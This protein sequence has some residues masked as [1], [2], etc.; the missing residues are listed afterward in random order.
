M[1]L[2]PAFYLLQPIVNWVVTIYS[3]CTALRRS[4]GGPRVGPNRTGEVEV[5]ADDNADIIAMYSEDY[6]KTMYRISRDFYPLILPPPPVKSSLSKTPR[7]IAAS[8]TWE[9][10]AT[11]DTQATT[12][13]DIS[14]ASSSKRV[15]FDLASP[16][17]THSAISTRSFSLRITPGRSLPLITTDLSTPQT[18][19]APTPF[20]REVP[21][22][23]DDEIPLAK[24]PERPERPPSAYLP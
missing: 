13:T 5:F 21:L 2:Y 9:S 4:W 23:D 1:L 11:S 12:N 20:P 24:R 16:A 14:R 10:T 3:I 22:D 19:K 17:S 6:N 18:P 7:F 15:H 8:P